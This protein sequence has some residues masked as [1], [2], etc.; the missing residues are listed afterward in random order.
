[1]TDTDLQKLIDYIYEMVQDK[2]NINYIASGSKPI[3]N[4]RTYSLSLWLHQYYK[5]DCVYYRPDIN[6]FYFVN[7]AVLF[8]RTKKLPDDESFI[9]SPF[10]VSESDE[11]EF[12]KNTSL[13]R[14]AG[15]IPYKLKDK[16]DFIVEVM[17]TC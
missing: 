6:A 11:D 8:D 3:G 12:Q 10:Y 17:K 14:G 13:E 15:C 4:V 1:M 5:V 7:P 16:I 2:N 9:P